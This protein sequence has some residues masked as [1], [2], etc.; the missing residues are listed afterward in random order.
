MGNCR[1]KD[2]LGYGITF[3]NRNGFDFNNQVFVGVGINLLYSDLVGRL[4]DT[5][6]YDSTYGYNLKANL[7]RFRQGGDDLALVEQNV[8]NELLKDERVTSVNCSIFVKNNTANV[9]ILVAVSQDETFSFVANLNM[10]N[11]S[12]LNF[13]LVNN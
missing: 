1:T 13:S 5:L 9:N 4:V 6:W 11:P 12:N 8:V 7:L 10:L 2:R 3:R